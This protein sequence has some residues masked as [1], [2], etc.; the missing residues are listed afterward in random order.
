MVNGGF[1]ENENS[2]WDKWFTGDIPAQNMRAN[3]NV[4]YGG[5]AS[6]EIRLQNHGNNSSIAQFNQYGIPTASIPVQEGGFY[7]MGCFFKSGGMSQPSEHWLEW[8]S[9]KT[10]DNTN[11]RPNLPWPDYFTP[12]FK[13]GTGASSW[14][15]ANR[16]FFVPTG[17]PNLEIRHRYTINSPGSGSVF[18]DNVFLRQLPSPLDARWTNL[19]SFGSTWRYATSKPASN[20]FTMGFN[21]AGWP[22]ARAKFGAGVAT[23][24]STV[25]PQRQPNYFFRRTFVLAEPAF[26]ELLLAA[27]CTDDY[28]GINYPLELYLNGQAVPATAIEV[29]T[30]VG[31]EIRYFD[32]TPFIDFLHAGTNTIAVALGNAFAVDWDNIAFDIAL[33]ST[34]SIAAAARIS[35]VERRSDGVLLGL[36]MP[37][38]TIWHL[39]SCD[40]LSATNW[41]AFD[42]FTNATIR[43]VL[44]TGQ[45]G[46]RPPASIPLR[47]YRLSPF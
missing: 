3:T 43:S 17:F 9:T 21:D 14:L 16:T 38:A 30:G 7:S 18:L 42:T 25:L 33:R 6:M 5:K 37:P 2:H 12:H 45:G 24:V 41:Q 36:A 20:W 26:Q 4:F 8:S 32:L 46:R 40:Q 19:V 34:P 35:S 44:D 27:V 47:F 13:V 22:V 39:E 10:A 23:N 1:E 28:G 31:N 29:T 15:Y 11:N